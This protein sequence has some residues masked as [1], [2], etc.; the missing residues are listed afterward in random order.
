MLIPQFWIHLVYK[1]VS[2]MT[3]QAYVGPDDLIGFFLHEANSPLTKV[4]RM[5]DFTLSLSFRN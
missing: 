3:S 2:R 1:G 5:I 4:D